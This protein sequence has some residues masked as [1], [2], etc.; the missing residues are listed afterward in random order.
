MRAALSSPWIRGIGEF[1]VAVLVL[2]DPLTISDG[3]DGPGFW[4]GVVMS[5]ALIPR[6]QWPMLS[7]VIATIAGIGMVAQLPTPQPIVL[8]VP[9]LV[10]S[11]ARHGDS[12][13]RYA[14]IAAGVLGASVGPLRWVQSVEQ[15]RFATW[16]MLAAVC[17]SLVISAW[18][19]GCL[20]KQREDYAALEREFA[21]ANIR[22][23]SQQSATDSRLA[24][25]RARTE[26]ARE[27]HDVV[28][29]SLSV[30]VVQAE[31]AQALATKKPEA[32]VK[33]LDV[34]ADTGR[35]SIQEMRRIVGVLRGEAHPTFGPTPSLPQIPDMVAAAGGRVKLVMP[36][37]LPAVPDTIG[38]TVYRVVQ[39][40]VTNFLKHAG[41][42]SRATVTVTTT[43]KSIGVRVVDDGLGGLAP[44]DGKGSG[45]VGMNERVMAMG[46]TFRAGTRSGGG[47]EVRAEIPLPQQMGRGWMT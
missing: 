7:L 9:F 28:A 16:G 15:S 17:F 14:V 22:H 5:A 4:W 43:P 44:N 38:L 25:G 37:Q 11:I 19:I 13:A 12:A 41:P 39:E 40:S 20:L 31:G 24:E 27:L 29:H 23:R 8:V 18:C 35:E 36:E 45:V 3:R 47:Y 34:I 21:E 30:M 2:V 10:Y 46:G 6:R 42:E 33:A 32:T 1:F 26:I